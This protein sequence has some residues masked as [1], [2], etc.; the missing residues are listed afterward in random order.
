M[1][2]VLNPYILAQPSIEGIIA[3]LSP[4]VVVDSTLP[5]NTEPIMLSC[6]KGTPC[7]NLPFAC[8]WASLAEVPVPQGDLSIALSP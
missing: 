2:I 7:F 6:K 5:V 4:I 3:C 1:D 8:Q